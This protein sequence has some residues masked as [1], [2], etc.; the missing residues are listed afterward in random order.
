MSSRPPA[1][2][3]P[4]CNADSERMFRWGLAEDGLQAWRCMACETMLEGQQV[5][6]ARA[7]AA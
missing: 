5:S 6:G 3:C 1:E 2:S 4:G 7:D